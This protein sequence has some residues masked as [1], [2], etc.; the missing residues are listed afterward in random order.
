[1][2]HCSL[3]GVP[4]R[5]L[6]SWARDNTAVTTWPCFQ[7]T[8][9]SFFALLIITAFAVATLFRH[10]DLKMLRIFSFPWRS[11]TFSSSRSL[12]LSRASLGTSATEMPIFCNIFYPYIRVLIS[13]IKIPVRINK[14]WGA[15]A[16][17]TWNCWKSA[18][19]QLRPCPPW[20]AD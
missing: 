7:D 16:P 11:I 5:N 3:R 10:R 12:I 13:N 4:H 2:H 9:L 15:R 20:R 19:W 8:K 14:I 6:Q 18:V 17:L 1:M